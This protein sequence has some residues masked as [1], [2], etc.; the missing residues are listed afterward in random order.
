[1]NS[2]TKC[3]N[4]STI[5]RKVARCD[6]KLCVVLIE[7]DIFNKAVQGNIPQPLKNLYIK[8]D[9][10]TLRHCGEMAC[11][12]EYL[13]TFGNSD[14][15]TGS[16]IDNRTIAAFPALSKFPPLFSRARCGAI[17]PSNF[18]AQLITNQ[19]E[20]ATTTFSRT[21]SQERRI[22]MG[23]R[24]TNYLVLFPDEW[25]WAWD[26]TMPADTCNQRTSHGSSSCRFEF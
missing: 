17:K 7:A 24:L 23:T 11:V 13:H 4:T 12:E 6:K 15:T 19:S 18:P 20:R 10:N 14:I 25:V 21:C 1:M 26:Y 5:C 3:L 16:S 2:I 9:V 22:C 8:F